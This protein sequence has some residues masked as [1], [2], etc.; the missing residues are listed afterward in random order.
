MFEHFV[1]DQRRQATLDKTPLVGCLEEFAA[2]LAARGH[3]PGTID[4]YGRVA[5]HYLAW[6]MAGRPRLHD[7]VDVV[8]NF[9]NHLRR[10]RCPLAGP[11]TLFTVRA[12]LHRLLVVLRRRGL[13]QR[14]ESARPS[15]VERVLRQFDRHLRD[16]CGLAE[17]TCTYRRRYV[18]EFLLAT[19]G[20][21]RIDARQIRPAHLVRFLMRCARRLRPGSVQVIG[22]CVKSFLRYQQLLGRCAPTLV[23]AIP[24]M[25]EYRLAR[26]PMVLSD[27]QVDRML[28][29]CDRDTIDGRRDFAVL[30]LLVDLGLRADEVG[31]LALDDIDW[32]AAVLR[33]RGTKVR[34]SS[35]LPLPATVGRA[36][37][38]Y[39]Q[40]RSQ[41]SERALFLRRCV[42]VGRPI[43]TDMV[44]RIARR[45]AARAGLVGALARPHALRHTAATRMLRRGASLKEVADVL[46]HST[47]DTTVI[48][49]KVDLP[50]LAAVALAWPGSRS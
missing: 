34:R 17:T 5:G 9:L 2:H 26:L 16:T 28:S 21:R 50:R 48:Y 44:R 47:L 41:T 45:A 37:A 19:F 33:L 49:A 12:A 38:D 32:R 13:V 7:D 39:L 25:P 18:R 42:P 8:R 27:A 10:C 35:V 4:A 3:T 40:V 15:E 6:M 20:N 36:I 31:Q 29:S 1:R 22:G 23:S 43:S 11:R 30:R 24:R 46:R 14:P